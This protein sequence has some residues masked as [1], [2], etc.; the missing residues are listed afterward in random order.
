MFLAYGITVW[1]TEGFHKGQG[2]FNLG[3]SFFHLYTSPKEEFY[4]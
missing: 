3:R 2:I 1:I 4:V